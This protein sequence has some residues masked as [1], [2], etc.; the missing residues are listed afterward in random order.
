M[1]ASAQTSFESLGICLL[2]VSQA[3]VSMQ[4]D[5]PYKVID[6]FLESLNPEP[7]NLPA[8]QVVSQLVTDQ[9]KPTES[10]KSLLLTGTEGKE[11]DIFESNSYSTNSCNLDP[12]C[13]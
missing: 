4:I 10:C 7:H 13:C 3:C 8:D 1:K 6:W 9:V 5:I 2:L 11:L 12:A